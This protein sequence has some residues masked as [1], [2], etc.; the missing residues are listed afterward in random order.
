MKILLS[1]AKSL[2]FEDPATTSEHTLPA[3]LLE[4]KKLIAV[5][6]K[7][8][9]SELQTLMGISE[10]LAGLNKARFSDWSAEFSFENAKQ[11]ILAFDGDVYT[12]LNAGSLKQK[13]LL[14]AQSRLRILSGLYGM[15]KPLDLIKPYRLEMGTQLKIDVKTA[16]LYD[17]WSKLL[18]DSLNQ[19]LG[20]DKKAWVLNLAS[21]EYFSVLK[22]D[23]IKA[24]IV[25]PQFLDYS[26]GKYKVISFYAKKARGL[27]TRWAI[28]NRIEKKEQLA[29]F[30]EEGYSYQADQSTISKPVF[31]RK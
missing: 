24:E 7:F 2:N 19:E 4:S 1:P 20:A 26:Q 23:Q 16:S 5:L 10:K 3:F 27:M 6:R 18:T 29:D 25:S 12:G 14:W 17:Y 28:L 22:K 30:C 13:D 21:N 9:A 8:K 11:A 15:L 31:C